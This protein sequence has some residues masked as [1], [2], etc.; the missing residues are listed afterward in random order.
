MKLAMSWLLDQVAKLG[1]EVAAGPRREGLG[2]FPQ[3]ATA[4][5]QLWR[6]GLMAAPKAHR[7][8]VG[9]GT[10]ISDSWAHS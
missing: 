6:P 4:V 8:H 7:A 2:A 5:A 1:R 3:G 10:L 9:E